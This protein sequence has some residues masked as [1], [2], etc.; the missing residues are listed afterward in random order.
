MSLLSSFSFDTYLRHQEQSKP[1][2]RT[3]SELFKAVISI[4][5]GHDMLLYINGSTPL[6]SM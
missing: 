3:N 6:F 1:A 2:E 5:L 4:D